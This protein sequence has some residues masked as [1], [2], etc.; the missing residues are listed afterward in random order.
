MSYF[1]SPSTLKLATDCPKC[2]WLQFRKKIK[3]PD[4]IFPSLPSGMDSVLKK[5]FEEYAEKDE[6]PPE[7][8]KLKGVKVF[9][10]PILKKW[11][12]YKQGL[13]YEDEK[14]NILKGAVDSILQ[15]GDKLI[16]LD[17]KTRGYPLKANTHTYYTDQLDLYN[18]L[19]R[20][21]NKKT[22]DYSYLL[23]YHPDKVIESVFQFHSDLIKI[24]VNIKKAQKIWDDALKLLDGPIPVASDECQF[25]KYRGLKIN[26]SLLDY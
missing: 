4:T 20:K 12:N 8:N 2:F 9:N 26:T 7:I 1:L 23:F 16:V 3:R 15:K 10:D 5:H 17:Y 21:N 25:C 22:E 11:Q 13:V 24:P 18:F 14:G 19:L 6:L